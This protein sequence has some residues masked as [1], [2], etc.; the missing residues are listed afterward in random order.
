MVFV[1]ADCK[2]LKGALIECARSKGLSW[3]R[4]VFL[5]EGRRLLRIPKKSPLD[6]SQLQILKELAGWKR[7]FTNCYITTTLDRA[8]KTT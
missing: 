8:L 3:K 7:R 2:E 6:F 4:L 5:F 1:T